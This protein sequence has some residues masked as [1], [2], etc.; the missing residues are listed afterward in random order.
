MHRVIM[1]DALA[2]LKFKLVIYQEGLL[3]S[4]IRGQSKG[5]PVGFSECLNSNAHGGW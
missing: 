3:G 5:D 4:L 1:T 2:C